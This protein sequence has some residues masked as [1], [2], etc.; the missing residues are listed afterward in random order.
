MVQTTE[1]V[2][3]SHWLSKD[4]AWSPAASFIKLTEQN[5]QVFVKFKTL[6]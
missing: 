2:K 3:A 5:S 6:K 4:L 1:H